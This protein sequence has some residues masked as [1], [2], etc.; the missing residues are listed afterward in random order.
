MKCNFHTGIE[1]TIRA[2]S[3]LK[4]DGRGATVKV[5]IHEPAADDMPESENVFD[6]LQW[7]MAMDEA[8]A[9]RMRERLAA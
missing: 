2:A 4:F 9:F 5:S 1:H 7:E 6:E 3:I 8:L